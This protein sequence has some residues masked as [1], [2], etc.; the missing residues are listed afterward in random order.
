MANRMILKIAI[1]PAV[2]ILALATTVYWRLQSLEQANREYNAQ[3][4]KLQSV[5][6]ELGSA[7]QL[8]ERNVDLEQR[9]GDL[10]SDLYGMDEAV[11]LVKYIS[12]RAADYNV[13]LNDFKFDLPKYIDQKDRSGEPGPFV[14]P[15]E[16]VLQGDYIPIG[17]FIG[18]LENRKFVGDMVNIKFYRDTSGKCSV[19]CELKGSLRFFDKSILEKKANAKA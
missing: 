12:K 18:N 14:V 17:K 2:L 11:E 7:G 3:A 5:Y 4:V 10:K 15:F 19:V 8:Q 9:L 16:C 6:A 1:I 13:M